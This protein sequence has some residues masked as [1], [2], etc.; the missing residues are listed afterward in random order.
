MEDHTCFMHGGYKQCRHNCEGV[1][2]EVWQIQENS[3]EMDVRGTGCK[4]VIE[5]VQDKF[6]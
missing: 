3:I 2:W 1:I 5:L 6:Q 4:D